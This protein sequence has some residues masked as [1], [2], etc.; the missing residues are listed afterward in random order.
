M[1]SKACIVG[2][3]Q[4]KLTSLATQPNLE[5]AVVVPPSWR[6]ERGTMVLEKRHA[7]RY[8]LIVAPIRFN[9]HFHLHYYPTLP[10]ILRRFRPDILHI[11]E[12]PYNFATFHAARAM[13][14]L[15]AD[16]KII[17]FSWQNILRKYPPPFAWMERY[18]YRQSVAAIAGNLEAESI[19][20]RKGFAKPIRVI[21]QFGVPDSFAPQPSPR[22]SNAF[23][24]GCAGRLV[25][26]KG[27]QVLLRALASAPGEWQLRIL[28]SGPSFDSLQTLA[29]ELGIAARVQFASWI[30]SN[31]M[32][33][34]YNSLDV[35]VVPSLTRPNWKEQFGRVLMEAMACG[36]P[37]I[38]SDSG[39][40]P[41]VT[42]NAGVI[43][44]END[45]AAL[46]RALTELM[47]DPARLRMLGQLGRARALAKFSEQRV[48]DDT[49]KFYNELL[50]APATRA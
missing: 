10:K 19:L 13:R 31:D 37:V 39:E 38:G 40:I 3:Y 46:T 11:D 35:L 47:R 22:D 9:G 15:S 26:E 34:F 48:V 50:D 18:M 20:R 14:Q 24:I 44:P 5:L 28:G 21:P 41:N 4:T 1:L 29:R 33:A 2:Q 49:Y 42:G 17:F 7:H 25:H 23:V 27:I 36:V 30:G 32:P 12:E 6:D 43:V 16:T 45:S 8:E